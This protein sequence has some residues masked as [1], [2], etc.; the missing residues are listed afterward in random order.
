MHVVSKFL[1]DGWSTR[2]VTQGSQQVDRE[3]K[4]GLA[5]IR[6]SNP[7]TLR[8]AQAAHKIGWH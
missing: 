7:N 8:Q 6:L 1:T 3:A 5:L 2:R 4:N